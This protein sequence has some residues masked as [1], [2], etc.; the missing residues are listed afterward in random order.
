MGVAGEGDFVEGNFGGQFV[1]ESVGIDE[2]AVVFFLQSLHFQSR[3][4]PVGVEI[5]IDGFQGWL[6]VG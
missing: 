6:S 5:L 1:L 3:F 2:N 4:L